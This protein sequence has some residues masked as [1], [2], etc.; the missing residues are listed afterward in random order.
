MTRN[1]TPNSLYYGDCLEIMHDWPAECIDLIYL[2]PPFNSKANYNQTFGRGNGVP[3]QVRAFTDTWI[4]GETAQQRL[5][6]L[7][8][9]V[10]HPAH[11]AIRG[12]T[13]VIGECGMLAYLTYMAERLTE[14]KRVLRDTGS[15]YLHCDSAAS[16]Y[17]KLLMDS[18]FGAGN[19]QNEIVWRRTNAHPLS[20]RKFDAVTD[21]I[22]FYTMGSKFT[23][24][25]VKI[26]MT[27][28]QIED[29]YHLSDDR[30]I[31]TSTDLTGGKQGGEAAYQPFKG[32]LPSAGRAWA[33]PA[34]SKLP[35]WAQTELKENYATLNQLEKCEELDRIGLI[36]WTS[37]G[38]PR[39]KRYLQGTPEQSLTGLWT[40][41]S[42]VGRSESLGYDTQKPLALLE[43]IVQA[44]SSPG[45]I[46]C[47]PFCG[48]GT[49]LDA[50]HR[51]GRRWLGIDVSPRAIDLIK[52]RRFKDASIP[53]HGIPEDMEA[54]RLMLKDNP[55]DFEAWAVTRIEGL[56]PNQTKVGDGGIDGRGRI[57]DD[58]DGETGLIIAQ[59]K[60]SGYSAATLRDFLHVIER[61]KATAGL[62]ITLNKTTTKNA[63]TQAA[64]LGTYTIGV[65]SFPRLQFWSIAEHLATPR[66]KPMLPPMA[67]P[68]TGKAI[69]R[70]LFSTNG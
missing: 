21:S 56:A 44:S 51:N 23:F 60:G 53:A 41:I 17:L 16:H 26:P 8:R 30:G 57:Y 54:A 46:V 63:L 33:P 45:D 11:K 19:F 62:F 15:I 39:L 31:F 2:D 36:H 20:I 48:G 55:F 42:P 52:Y 7:R 40:D 65:S 37:N 67:D 27:E 25:G 38:R 5:E 22:L 61:E 13:E 69:Q 24:H 35:D 64:A 70:D 18:I 14:M 58:I 68:D 28:T 6:R 4:W 29:L 59:V 50:A 66:I 43:R 49:T 1:P 47:D 3:A 10:N 12:L 32:I 9:A 34:L